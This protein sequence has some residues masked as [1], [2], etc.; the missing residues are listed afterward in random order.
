MKLNVSS[1][2]DTKDFVYEE[3]FGNHI[4]TRVTHR[5]YFC[6]ETSNDANFNAQYMKG[7]DQEVSIRLQC[8]PRSLEHKIG[9]SMVEYIQQHSIKVKMRVTTSDTNFSNRT[10][11]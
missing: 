1:Y 3:L 5:F 10:F 8:Y 2:E 9:T 11:R 4:I 7:M 6:E